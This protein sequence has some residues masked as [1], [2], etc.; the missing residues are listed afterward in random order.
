MYLMGL[1]FL[2]RQ[3]LNNQSSEIR[4]LFMRYAQKSQPVT[5]PFA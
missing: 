3:T 1:N 2:S 4:H 5:M